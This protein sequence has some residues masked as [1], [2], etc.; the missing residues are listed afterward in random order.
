VI[1]ECHIFPLASF[2]E[3]WPSSATT[4]C[5]NSRNAR[6]GSMVSDEGSRQTDQGADRR[7]A[8]R[9]EP[10]L[11]YC[12]GKLVKTISIFTWPLLPRLLWAQAR[13]ADRGNSL[14]TTV[15]I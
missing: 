13:T 3:H 6:V 2:E 9:H 4:D 5:S 1:E 8:G 10:R 11:H 15:R 7:L 12:R 14:S